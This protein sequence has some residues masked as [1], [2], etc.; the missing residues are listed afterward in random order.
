MA[1]AEREELA[2]RLA[3]LP[4]ALRTL[5]KRQQYVITERRL[6]EQATAPDELLQHYRISLE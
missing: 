6:K 5:E 4:G 1:L 3:L 2:A